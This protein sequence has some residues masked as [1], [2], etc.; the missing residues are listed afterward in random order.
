MANRE[1]YRPT[2]YTQLYVSKGKL[3]EGYYTVYKE[4]IFGEYEPSRVPVILKIEVSSKNVEYEFAND[5]I[6]K[7]NVNAIYIISERYEPEIVFTPIIKIIQNNNQIKK[8]ILH[9]AKDYEY[10]HEEYEYLYDSLKSSEIEYVRYGHRELNWKYY[11][12]PNKVND[13][14]YLTIY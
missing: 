2:Q 12:G 6:N 3:N 4:D 11:Y 7:Y 10:S 9:L 1:Y 14:D 13:V 8:V 5:L